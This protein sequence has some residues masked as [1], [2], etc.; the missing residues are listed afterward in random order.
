MTTSAMT[1]ATVDDLAVML[2]TDGGFTF[3]PSTGQAV[4]VGD[5][6]GWAVARAGSERVIGPDVDVDAFAAA[7]AAAESEARATGGLVGG[8]YS[9]ERRTYMCEVTD[10]H[11]VDRATA[12]VIG[13]T[14]DQETVYDLATGEVAPVPQWGV[15]G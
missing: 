1:A 10:V 8:W 9:R 5:R 4:N 13:M 6:V 14:A 7:F 2:A 11:D 3:D 12:L 15:D